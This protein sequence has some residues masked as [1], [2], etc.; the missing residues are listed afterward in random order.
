MG[1]WLLCVYGLV[2]CELF[3]IYDELLVKLLVEWVIILLLYLV[4]V[5]L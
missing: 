2:E 4:W 1:E 3:F 5:E